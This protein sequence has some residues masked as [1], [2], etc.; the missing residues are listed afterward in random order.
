MN[1]AGSRSEK[2]TCFLRSALTEQNARMTT[3]ECLT[4]L[5]AQRERTHIDVRRIPF[6]ELRQWFFDATTGDLA[7]ASGKFFAIRGVRVRTNWGT[8]REWEQ[9]II[10]QPE[11]GL[12]GVLA[13]RFDGILH[14]LMQA[15]CEPG[16]LNAVQLSPTLQATRSN[17]TRVHQG[18]TPLYL[19][20]F[21]NPERHRVLVDQL[22]SEQGARFLRKRNRNIIVE[23]AEEVPVHEGYRWLTLGQIKRLLGRDNV[24][25]MDARTVI[26][27]IPFGAYDAETLDF[28]TSLVSPGLLADEYARAL[29]VS[30]LLREGALHTDDAV[31]SW[32][33]GLK[34][35]YDLFVERIP[36][37]KVR[38]WVRDDNSIHHEAGKYF[39]VLATEVAIQNREVPSWTQPMVTPAQGGIIAF[40]TRR[41]DGV[42]HFL[43]QAKVEAGNLDVVEMA[44]SVQCIT[45]DYR[46][47]PEELRPPFLDYVLAVPPENVRY[48]ALQSEEG[49]RFY[50][51][52]N[53][54]MI[55]EA[56]DEFP[57]QVPESFIWMTLNQLNRFIRFNNF[58]NI[59]ARSLLST[60]SFI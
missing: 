55:I 19:E 34:T 44:P 25:N 30:G 31:L 22:Q 8:V 23:V 3:E 60:I 45:G 9:P 38:G 27:G 24:V 20:Y 37:K 49:G 39:S 36:L 7:H 35:R 6:S 12:L 48:S 59:Q 15:K 40:V 26:S 56:G 11:V 47:A 1:E 43:V 13:T 57:T 58:V 32:F 14:F 18:K 51:E 17:F 52:Q 50:Q 54:N 42:L 4:W 10:D 33:A 2:S 5:A 41:I 28:V 46:E 53:R 21:L 29:F 16:N